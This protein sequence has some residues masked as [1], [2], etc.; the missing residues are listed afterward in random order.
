[1]RFEI[2]PW[3][4]SFRGID[5][6]DTIF[7]LTVFTTPPVTP[8][9]HTLEVINLGNASTVPL[10]ID[11]FVV[12]HGDVDAST[13]TVTSPNINTNTNTNT[14]TGVGASPKN[15]SNP[16]GSTADPPS[17]TGGQKNNIGII[18]G[19]AAGALVLVAAAVV[20]F[21]WIRKRRQAKAIAPSSQWTLHESNLSP[22]GIPMNIPPYR[23]A[24]NSS[25]SD[26][27]NPPDYTESEHG[28]LT[29]PQ[30]PAMQYQTL[31]QQTMAM[32]YHKVPQ[33]PVTIPQQMAMDY[34]A[35]QQTESHRLHITPFEHTNAPGAPPLRRL[36]PEKFQLPTVRS[37]ESTSS[38]AQLLRSPSSS[39]SQGSSNLSSA[40]SL[41]TLPP[42]LSPIEPL[43]LSAT[44]QSSTL[45]GQSKPA[46][47]VPPKVPPPRRV[48]P[49]LQ[50]AA[51]LPAYHE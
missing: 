4:S 42:P 32:R 30:Q 8:G 28:F 19:A 39:Y 3:V 23:D 1:M 37:M 13:A 17:T 12:H 48:P 41:R 24:P 50:E 44:P 25:G 18:V 2:P 38:S 10:S 47:A 9:H 5:A 21:F 20:L 29:G 34:P 26:V 43:T 14:N 22:H 46:R 31:P 40:G 45:H 36:P 15:S 51:E 6:N 35:P 33:Q 16:S 49:K 27:F 7:R 11:Y